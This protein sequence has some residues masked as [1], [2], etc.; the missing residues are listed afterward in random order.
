MVFMGSIDQLMTGG[1]TGPTFFH[2]RLIGIIIPD[3]HGE[4]AM[5]SKTLGVPTFETT[6]KLH[7]NFAVTQLLSSLGNSPC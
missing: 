5:F 7:V 6:F 1:P 2:W 3:N 4:P